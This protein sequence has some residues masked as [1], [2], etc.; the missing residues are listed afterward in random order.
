MHIRKFV[1]VRK[2]IGEVTSRELPLRALVDDLTAEDLESICALSVG[3]TYGF[4][5]QE[6]FGVKRVS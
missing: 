4:N 2:W 1:Y 3:E 5:E 6:P